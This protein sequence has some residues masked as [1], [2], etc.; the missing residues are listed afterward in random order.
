MKYNELLQEY[1]EF[2]EKDLE[3][4]QPIVVGGKD[5]LK[6]IVDPLH[7]FYYPEY[8]LAKKLIHITGEVAKSE[9]DSLDPLYRSLRFLGKKLENSMNN[10]YANTQTRPLEALMQ[11][12][13]FAELIDQLERRL[14]AFLA[15]RTGKC[16][17]YF[18]FDK[19]KRSL[20]Y[21][22]SGKSVI[23][24]TS[25]PHKLIECLVTKQGFVDSTAIEKC[26]GI[27]NVSTTHQEVRAAVLKAKRFMKKSFGLS[28]AIRNIPKVGYSLTES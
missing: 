2:K 12:G 21:I 15:N 5:G 23:L 6:S 16:I 8:E 11:A 22:P 1:W 27:P 25:Q 26:T 4:R 3:Y 28:D 9:R 13:Q 10:P 19:T 7:E 24:G 14:Y 18:K 20:T 17:T